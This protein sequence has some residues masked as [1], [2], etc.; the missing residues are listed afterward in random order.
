MK[1]KVIILDTTLRDGDQS[2]LVGLK[3]KNKLKI[4]LALEKLGID[5][6]EA[7]FPISSPGDFQAV[8][9][10]SKNIR[11]SKICSLSRCIEKDIY[12]AAEAM[13]KSKNFRIHLFIGTSDLHVKQKLRK[14]FEEIIDMSIFS[15]KKALKYTDDIQFSCE[16]AGRTSLDNL[17]KIVEKVIKNG[18]KTVNI[19]DTVGYTIPSQFKNIIK[20][21]YEKVPN[22]DKAIISAHCHNDL[23]MASGNAISSIESGV[24]QIEGTITG[25]GERAGNTALEE[26][27]LAIKIHSEKLGVY[28]NIN[29]KEIYKTSKLISKLCNSPI[30]SIKAIIGKNAFLH[31]SGIHQDGFLKNRKNYE[32][33]NPKIIG[34][35]ETK[36]NLTA[37]S[38]RA[39]IQYHMNRMGYKNQ[40]Y[41]L[42]KLYSRF[43]VLADDKGKVFDYNLEELA[44]IKNN[45]NNKKYFSIK[46]FKYKIKQNGIYKLSISLICGNTIRKEK[47]VSKKGILYSLYKIIVRITN[48]KFLIKNFQV[49][50][51]YSK[52]NI[53]KEK[54]KS[55]ITVEYEKRIFHGENIS[56]NSIKSSLKSIINILNIIWMY[57]IIKNKKI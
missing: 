38:G 37:K 13:S 48:L 28:T 35:K 39:A 31:S 6:I 14:N 20:F 22:I 7:G 52:K 55:L 40:D 3:P 19:P 56:S 15:I 43:L 24:R 18:V 9:L 8:Q 53:F 36:L 29:F 11:N 17:C 23:G 42:N 21:L 33:I 54:S 44:F 41:N 5:I 12:T 25:I 49:I 1:E 51:T 2:L 10:I 46:Y 27:I 45:D 57:K 50:Q 4:A 34:A 32:I 16:D 26:I 30:S 47:I